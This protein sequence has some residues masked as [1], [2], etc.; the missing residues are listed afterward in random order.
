MFHTIGYKVN[1]DWSG[2]DPVWVADQVQVQEVWD[3]CLNLEKKSF[4]I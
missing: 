4:L 1:L 2:S 3:G